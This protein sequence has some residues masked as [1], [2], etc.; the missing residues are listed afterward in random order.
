MHPLANIAVSA[1]RAAGNTIMRYWRQ[2]GLG[3]ETKRANDYVT[4]AD[5]EAEAVIIDAIRRKH[6]DHAIVAEESGQQHG[7]RGNDVEWIIDPIDGTTNFIRGIPH[8]AVSIAARVGGRIQHGVV[9]DPFKDELFTASNGSGAT[10]DG[11]RI[12]VT[13]A[14]QP[15]GALLATGFAYQRDRGIGAHLNLFNT[16]LE[17]CGDIRRGG[18]A[19]LDLAYVAAGRLDGYWEF[20]LQPWDLAAGMLLVREAGGIGGDPEDADPLE[21]GCV[22][23][24]NPKLHTWLRQQSIR[25]SPAHAAQ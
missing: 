8:F 14:N 5:R 16:V 17:A 25:S 12:R 2:G 19:S 7:A 18:A 10:L 20:G 13:D 9:Y 1:A 11:R 24:A 22:L 23:A 15:R 6:P 21:T 3:V 4:R